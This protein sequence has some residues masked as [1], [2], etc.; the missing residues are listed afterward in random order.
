MAPQ[1]RASRSARDSAVR[2]QAT[3]NGSL[4]ARLGDLQRAR[5]VSAM[6]D[7]SCERGAGDV[8]VAHVVARSGVSRRTFYEAF[9]DR[10]DCFVA[11]FEQALKLAS[12]RVLP[13]Y[14]VPGKWRER[15]RA[16][17]VA[18]LAFLDEEPT[19]GRLLIVES[20]AGGP[21]ALRRRNEVIALAAEAID[22]GRNE[23]KSAAPPSLTAEGVVGGV[24]SILHA[25]MA[26]R[27]RESLIDLANP[28][29]STIVLPYVG[30]T[31]AKRELEREV[32]A[33][34]SAPK[35][36]PLLS[37]PFKGAGMRLT[38]RTVMVLLAIAE[39]PGASNRRV[40]EQAGIADQGQISKLLARLERIGL[41]AN[42]G[43]GPGQGGPNAWTLTE[44]GRQVTQTVRAHTK[45]PK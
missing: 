36:E 23:S 38:Y 43:M 20:L 16:A 24:L 21:K 13:A 28:L 17:L 6:F 34:T 45:E 42:T 19:I 11:A 15:V 26:E 31:A 4:R 12:E 39:Q 37:D 29:M 1:R 3:R 33:P 7:V 5:I 30:A 32:N 35:S 22:E 18:L 44:Q 2:T 27:S 25:R 10:E 8:T 40:G 14:A 41:V 9:S